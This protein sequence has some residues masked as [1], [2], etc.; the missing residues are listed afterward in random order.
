[1]YIIAFALLIF[2]IVVLGI[3][4]Y[5]H[6]EDN[7]GN[8]HA[9]GDIQTLMAQGGAQVFVACKGESAGTYTV[10]DL[11]NGGRLPQ[12]YSLTTASGNAWICQV[13]G[14]GVNGGNVTLVLW[15]GPPLQAGKYG[16]GSFQNIPLQG[17]VAWN[18]AAVLKEQ[19]SAETGVVVGVVGAGSTNMVAEQNHSVYSLRGLLNAPTYTT[20]A[21]EEGL[22]AASQS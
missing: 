11:I 6:S 21:M 3:L 17:A 8:L 15:D 9:V 13:S 7:I 16:Q 10:Q 1:M 19:L 18:S 12:G 4:G 14:G 20:P 22:V 5:I 2:V